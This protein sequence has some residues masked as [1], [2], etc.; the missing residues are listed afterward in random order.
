LPVANVATWWLADLVE[1]LR[2]RCLVVCNRIAEGC[3]FPNEHSVTP[4]ADC[5]EQD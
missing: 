4:I 3:S 5:G 1:Q 2:E